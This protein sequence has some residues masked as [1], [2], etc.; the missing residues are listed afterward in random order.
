MPRSGQAYPFDKA[1]VA[2]L[3]ARL[4]EKGWTQSD[5]AR[6]VRAGRSVIWN[7]VNLKVKQSP[8]IPD[9]HAAVGWSAPA[10]LATDEA[11]EEM[12]EVWNQLN[13]QD[14]GR[15]LERGKSLLELEALVK[16]SKGSKK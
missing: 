1:W 8:Y 10:P 11:T 2:R 12:L 4:E 16:S 6:E 13:A 7:I 15:L 5:L 14:R 9:I 3:L